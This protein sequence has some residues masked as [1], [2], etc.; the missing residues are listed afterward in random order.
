MSNPSVEQVWEWLE[1]IPDP[2][3][4]VISLI[5][6]G[7]IRNVEWQGDTCVVAVTPTYSGCPATSMINMD[8]ETK[9]RDCGLE[10]IELKQQ[11]SPAWTT[12]WMSD[13]ARDALEK[14]GIAPPQ[15]AGGP[16]R[17]PRC[18]GDHLEKLSQ[19]GSTPCKAQWRCQDCLEP[20]E[21]FKCI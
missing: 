5:D 7:I 3:I 8:I 21:Y 16:K 9:L 19:F 20:F 2:E 17:C 15:A 4:P 12:D 1:T 10:K 18:G 11:L 14:Y 13:K 6:L